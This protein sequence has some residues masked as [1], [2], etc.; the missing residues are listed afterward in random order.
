MLFLKKYLNYASNNELLTIYDK[1]QSKIQ[2][3]KFVF[4]I[5]ILSIN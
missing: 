4:L 1:I 5:K 2:K 3:R